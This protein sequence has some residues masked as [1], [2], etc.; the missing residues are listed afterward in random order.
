MEKLSKLNIL[1]LVVSVM[2]EQIDELS[3]KVKSIEIQLGIQKILTE[4]KEETHG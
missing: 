4:S 2:E 3:E 1:E